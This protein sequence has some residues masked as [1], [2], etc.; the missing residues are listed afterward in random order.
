MAAKRRSPNYPSI[1]LNK[2]VERTKLLYRAYE[3]GE[4]NQVDAAKAWGYKSDNGL[5]RSAFGALRQYGLVA[6]KKGSNGRL[7]ARG[8][9]IALREATS[10]EYRQALRDAALEPPLFKEVFSEGK[11]TA[12]TDALLQHLVMTKGFTR[13]GASRFIEVLNATRSL[14]DVG[15]PGQPEHG[16]A[17]AGDQGELSEY[18]GGESTPT[19]QGQPRASD[20]EATPQGPRRTRVPLRLAGGF[21]AA[22]ELPASM[23]DDAW[24]HMLNYLNVMRPAY[25]TLSASGDSHPMQVDEEQD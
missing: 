5:S 11:A 6:Q 2:A 7:T 1:D 14:A 15:D 12:A 23:T 25:V 8:L 3:Q 24:E 22:I 10:A 21:E 18:G 13:D 16:K 20:S 17:D 19:A 4:F 9:T